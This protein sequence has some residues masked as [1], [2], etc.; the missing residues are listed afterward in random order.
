M[1]RELGG[2]VEDVAELTGV[3]HVHRQDVGS[4]A[5]VLTEVETKLD[6]KSG[7]Y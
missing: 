4:A 3:G 2:D 7:F 6:W 5:N 1:K